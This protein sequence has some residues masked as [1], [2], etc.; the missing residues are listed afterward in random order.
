M[1]QSINAEV[2]LSKEDFIAMNKLHSISNRISGISKFYLKTDF[3]L[4]NILEGEIEE[5]NLIEVL[6]EIQACEKIILKTDE[7][8][9]NI[10]AKEG[11]VKQSLFDLIQNAVAYSPDKKCNVAI[12]TKARSVELLIENRISVLLPKAIFVNL[13]KKIITVSGKNPSC[14]LYWAARALLDSQGEIELIDYDDYKNDKMF[15]I[16]IRFKKC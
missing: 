7:K 12:S 6:K 14:G 5:F 13:G 15:R 11:A 9:I 3:I 2:Q 4:K 10:Q 1:T 8:V 16:I